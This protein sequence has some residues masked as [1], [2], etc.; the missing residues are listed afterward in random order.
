MKVIKIKKA[1]IIKFITLILFLVIVSTLTTSFGMQHYYN[2]DFVTGLVTASTLNV[3][4]GPG[5]KYP[6]IAQVKK[7]EYI[8]VFA[9]VGNWYVVQ[10]EGDYIGAV[11]KEYVKPI[12]PNSG[13]GS[14]S[15]NT[16]SSNNG[17]TTNLTADEQEVFNLINK[18][19]TNNGLS[20]LQID[21]EAQNVA[22]IKAQDMVNNNYFSHNSPTYGS[23]FD[24]LK[25][26]KVSYKTAGENIAG[27]SSNTAAVNAWMNS[28]GHKANILNSSFNYTGIG[29]VNGSKYGKIYVQIFIGK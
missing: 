10:V 8:R 22:R 3:R 19:R 4:S 21:A 15:G 25:S 12:Y 23:P 14:S 26:F 18:Q 29:V 17:L 9:G 11:S 27:N 24:M 5:T 13:G 16:G 28:S 20:P 7:N 2:L 6:V 1:S